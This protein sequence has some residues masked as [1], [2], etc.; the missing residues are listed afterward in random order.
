MEYTNPDNSNSGN[1]HLNTLKVKAE[2]EIEADE[3]FT[4]QRNKKQ[5]LEKIN[6]DDTFD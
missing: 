5:L 1:K 3:E 4:A 6:F 2:E